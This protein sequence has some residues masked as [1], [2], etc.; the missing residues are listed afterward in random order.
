MG[1]RSTK[2]RNEDWVNFKRNIKERQWREKNIRKGRMC[3]NW[4]LQRAVSGRSLL[5]TFCVISCGH[6]H[7]TLSFMLAN[8]TH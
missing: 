6:L 2:G 3:G 7:T 5:K 4:V 8:I 1:K